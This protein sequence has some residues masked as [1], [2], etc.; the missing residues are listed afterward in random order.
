MDLSQKPRSRGTE[1]S[2]VSVRHSADSIASF[3]CTRS[4][5]SPNGN[6]FLSGWW[7]D[8]PFHRVCAIIAHLVPFICV[9][10]ARTS[11][12]K[13]ALFDGASARHARESTTRDAVYAATVHARGAWEYGLSAIWAAAGNG[14]VAGDGVHER[15][16]VRDLVG[17]WMLSTDCGDASVGGFAG[18]GE[19]V[20]A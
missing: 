17:F 15:T 6:S 11:R 13:A 8:T 18:L 14:V 9:I 20:V 12:Q 4:N 1:D 10:D 7:T 3:S 5:S 2:S 19:R 16:G